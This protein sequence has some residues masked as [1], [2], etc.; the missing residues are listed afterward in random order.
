MGLVSVIVLTSVMTGCFGNSSDSGNS[1]KKISIS[2]STS[3]E[4]LSKSFAE[5][6]KEVD[7]SV[8]VSVEGGGSGAAIKNVDSD[9]STIGVLSR[10]LK[11]DETQKGFKE[12]TIALDG[13]SVI[14]NT[15]NSISDLTMDQISKIFTG[16]IKN[17]KEVGGEDATIV[18]VGR[19]SGSGTRD[20]F[21]E[22]LG[23]KEKTKYTTELNE[24]GQIKAQVASTKGA[25][26]YISS[27]YVDNSIKGLKIEGYEATEDNIKSDKYKIQRPFLMVVKPDSE[28]REEVK[29]FIDFVMSDA[30]QKI[31]KDKGFIPYK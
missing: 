3:V 4:S 8:I 29:K 27:G 30:C 23:V 18:V 10:K 17:W 21:E 25:I 2:G 9:V 20:G 1:G 28:K 31:V 24:T 14:V 7:S 5:A 13:I 6:Y 11:D 26:G 19:E 12:Y 22:I 15:G 16:E